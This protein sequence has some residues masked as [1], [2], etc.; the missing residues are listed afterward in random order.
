MSGPSAV[1]VPGAWRRMRAETRGGQTVGSVGVGRDRRRSTLRAPREAARR[2][3]LAATAALLLAS[4]ASGAAGP[5]TDFTHLGSVASFN[6]AA[7]DTT[8]LD[9]IAIAGF[10]VLS[11]SDWVTSKGYLWLRNDADDRGIGYCSTSENCGPVNSVGNGDWNELSNESHTEIIRLTLPSGYRWSGVWVSSLDDGG[12]KSN[13]TGTLY[14]S[15]V[16]MP[17]L[18]SASSMVFS[19]NDLKPHDEGSVP[20]PADA[21]SALYLFFRAGSYEAK[22]GYPLGKALN[23]SNNDYLVWGVDVIPVPESSTYAML[24]AGLAVLG[25]VARKRMHRS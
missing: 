20:L 15:D 7:V 18:M 14:W 23:G 5:S 3:A 9:S 11:P 25:F 21:T 4:P 1:P 24:L 2:F 10:V 8:M 17:D 19:H 6:S 13:E 16:S 12:T 22:T